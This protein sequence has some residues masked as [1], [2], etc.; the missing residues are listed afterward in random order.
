MAISIPACRW[1][2]VSFSSAECQ[3]RHLAEEWVET[4]CAIDHFALAANES[5]LTYQVTKGEKN[6]WRLKEYIEIFWGPRPSRHYIYGIIY[7]STY[8]HI[9]EK[10]NNK[11]VISSHAALLRK[12]SFAMS[13]IKSESLACI[14]KSRLCKWWHF[15]IHKT[16]FR[17]HGQGESHTM[18]GYS[19]FQLLKQQQ[20]NTTRTL[21]L[22]IHP[23]WI[24]TAMSK[25]GFS[26][27]IHFKEE[28][29]TKLT[30]PFRVKRH[31]SWLLNNTMI[32]QKVHENTLSIFLV[33]VAVDRRRFYSF[34]NSKFH[35]GKLLDY[36]MD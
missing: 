4:D 34:F 2:F 23:T 32:A 7:R 16:I 9:R 14:T 13:S 6:G 27:N 24:K 30:L 31:C 22:L 20:Q 29:G 28:I 5:E 3:E 18:D 15:R 10:K 12:R 1:R 33:S 25:L 35:P 26:Q 17:C 11:L 36:L 8:R 21:L 19:S